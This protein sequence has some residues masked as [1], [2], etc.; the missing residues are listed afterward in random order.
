MT[1]CRADMTWSGLISFFLIFPLQIVN[2]ELSRKDIF[3]WQKTANWR[4]QRCLLC[5]S[6]NLL[7]LPGNRDKQTA[8]FIAARM[9]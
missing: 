8:N 3:Y 7:S 2:D 1:E 5:R 4:L 9:L 6:W